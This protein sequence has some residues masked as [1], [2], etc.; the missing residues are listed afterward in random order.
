MPLRTRTARLARPAPAL[1]KPA[2]NLDATLVRSRNGTLAAV[3]TAPGFVMHTAAAADAGA[4]SGGRT[5]TR[6][7]TDSSR[8]DI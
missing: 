3:P 4:A 2:S 1:C 8:I 6:I 7:A 5:A